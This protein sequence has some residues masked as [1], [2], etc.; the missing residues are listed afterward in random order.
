MELADFKRHNKFESST[1]STDY[2]GMWQVPTIPKHC[3]I[4][5]VPNSIRRVN[6]EAY[7]PQLVLIGPLNHSLKSQA[8]KCRGDVTNAK[9]MGY[10]NMEAHKKFY[11]A[12]FAKR[13][14]E[15]KTIDGFRRM[16]KADEDMIRASYSESTA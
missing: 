1:E 8:L 10:L 6:P 11:L 12:E 13:V 4:Y 15:E 16:I 2:P 9:S 14:D 3:C 7:T 5:R